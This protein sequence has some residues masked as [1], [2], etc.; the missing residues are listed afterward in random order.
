MQKPPIVEVEIHVTPLGIEAFAKAVEAKLMDRAIEC[1]RDFI[2]VEGEIWINE[3]SVFETAFDEV[4]GTL[5]EG[6][7]ERVYELVRDHSQLRGIYD[8]MKL[9]VKDAVVEHRERFESQQSVYAQLRYVGMS[10]RD[11]I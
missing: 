10:V 8:E 2:D 11:F 4:A 3:D 9:L 7:Y 1:W 5:P 6:E